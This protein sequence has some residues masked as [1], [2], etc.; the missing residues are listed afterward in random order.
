LQGWLGPG[1]RKIVQQK[2]KK[3]ENLGVETLVDLAIDFVVDPPCAS[4]LRLGT[5]SN[6]R[7]IGIAFF[8]AIL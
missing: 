5:G 2:K 8:I 7:W 3:S 4:Q 1:A 6:Y